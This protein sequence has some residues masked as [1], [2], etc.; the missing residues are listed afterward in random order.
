MSKNNK[1]N[2]F[3]V[4]QQWV[5]IPPLATNDSDE[6]ESVY[7]YD[8]KKNDIYLTEEKRHIQQEIDAYLPGTQ[9]YDILDRF[10]GINSMDP[11][12]FGQIPQLNIKNGQFADISDLPDNIHDLQNLS[13]L[14][15]KKLQELQN[16]EI[17][18]DNSKNDSQVDQQDPT[19]K[20]TETNEQKKEE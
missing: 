10:A 14:A 2:P 3:I 17:N 1:E 18:T 15:A 13:A 19:Q 8:S 11:Q 7:K 16:N 12:Q 4:L 5:D 9:I 20:T 6:W